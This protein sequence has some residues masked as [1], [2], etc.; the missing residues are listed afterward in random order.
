M[1]AFSGPRLHLAL[2]HHPVVSK[3]GETI[4]SAVT[5]LD[6][7]D[8]ARTAKTYGVRSFFVVTPL[9]DQIDLVDKIV[10]HWVS[11]AQ[12]PSAAIPMSPGARSSTS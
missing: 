6:L 4:A 1:K 12:R 8:I 2:I 9:E 5:N 7:H 11:G 3:N 10:A